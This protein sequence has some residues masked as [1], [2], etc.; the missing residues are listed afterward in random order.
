MD[1][2]KYH[3]SQPVDIC[4]ILFQEYITSCLYPLTILAYWKLFQMSEGAQESLLT[5]HTDAEVL[6]KPM[7][8]LS[9]VMIIAWVSVPKH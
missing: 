7:A 1:G 5:H 3:S 9:K 4:Q 2:S 6:G 8:H